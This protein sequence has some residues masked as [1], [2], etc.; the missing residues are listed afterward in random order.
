[1]PAH[2]RPHHARHVVPAIA[3]V[4]LLMAAC[5]DTTGIERAT[6]SRLF[7]GQRASIV[8]PAPSSVTVGGTLDTELGCAADWDPGCAA[9]HLTYD[10]GDD[11]W[12]GTW[13]LPAGSYDYKAALNDSWDENY[14]LN[15][16]PNGANITMSLGSSRA[17]KFYYDHKTH[18]ITDNVSSPIVVAP[19]SF[20]ADLGCAADW[21]PSCLRAWLQDPD[22]DGTYTMST[23]VI[24]A[25]NYEAK[26]A[27]GET[28]DVNYG[29]GGA[30][31]GANIEFTVPE[32]GDIVLFSF[33]ATTHVLTITATPPVSPQ[34]ISITSTLPSSAVV[35][36]SFTLSATG[37]GSGNPVVFAT[38]TS[39]TCTTTGTNGTTLTLIATGGCSVQATQAG[40]ATYAAATPLTL[41]VT[42]TSASAAT[43]ALR[44]TV[45]TSGIARSVRT[46]LTDKLD[47]A[48][49]ALAKGQTTAACKQLTAFDNQV[50][51]Q[52]GTSIPAS[53]ADAWLAQS[54]AIRRAIGC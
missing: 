44:A 42:V 33:N 29:Q 23:N 48:L 49:A 19:G 1:M 53:T 34:T 40:S 17:V 50:R 3:A 5:S 20:Q 47:A 32:T 11:V 54:A 43:S 36:S 14:G 51:S 45:A 4:A 13:T 15:A 28:W 18:W 31:G 35:G 27:V 6:E 7:P 12:Q 25:G 46:G 8:T 52:R 24:P 37:G 26:V 39:S 22:G 9:A 2:P 16:M 21:D 38:Q 41:D 10:A 30:P